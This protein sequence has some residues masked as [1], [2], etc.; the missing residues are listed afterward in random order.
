[1]KKQQTKAWALK[2]IK[3]KESAA[4]K[5]RKI[6]HIKCNAWK[7]GLTTLI[8]VY[9]IWLIWAVVQIRIDVRPELGRCLVPKGSAIYE[10][11]NN[12]KWIDCELT[13]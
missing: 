13:V 6:E 11:Y 7:Y 9:I 8:T 3:D 4:K 12:L 2:R 1:M 10:W 5:R